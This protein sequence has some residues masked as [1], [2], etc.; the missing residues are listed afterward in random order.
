MTVQNVSLA[1]MFGWLPDMVRI[2]KSGWRRF[3]SASLWTMLVFLLLLGLFVG[4][5]IGTGTFDFANAAKPMATPSAGFWIVYGLFIAVNLALQPA[6]HAGWFALCG[7]VDVGRSGRGSDVF[8]PFLRHPGVWGRCLVIALITLVVVVA[9]FCVTLLPFIP[10]FI[11]FNKAM[12]V[13]QAS[14]AAG[15]TS[16]APFPPIGIFFGYFLFLAMMIFVQV[17]SVVAMGEVAARPTPPMAAMNLAA[18][19]VLRNGFKLL[20]LFIVVSMAM[21]VAMMVVFVPV[22]LIGVL[23]SFVSP[24]L[25]AVVLCVAYLGLIMGMYALMYVFHYVLWKGLLAGGAPANEPETMA[26]GV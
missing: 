12:A 22:V 13:Y 1:T 16:P 11:A 21:G 24:V 26:V 23:L 18:R 14:L 19:A 17:V 20:L 2:L 25:M 5:V 7:D 9:V 3:L 6:L 15:V 10:G 8:A 4:M